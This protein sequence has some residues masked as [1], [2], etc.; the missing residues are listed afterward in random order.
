MSPNTCTKKISICYFSCKSSLL[1][2]IIYTNKLKKPHYCRQVTPFNDSDDP[3]PVDLV[4]QLFKAKPNN[5]DSPSLP[6][7]N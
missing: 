2:L 5:I 6:P 7:S 1:Q 4:E 3:S